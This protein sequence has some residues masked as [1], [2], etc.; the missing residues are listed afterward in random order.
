MYQCGKLNWFHFS[1]L[2]AMWHRSCRNALN[3]MKLALFLL[4]P[5]SPFSWSIVEQ[6]YLVLKEFGCPMGQKS[7]ASYPPTIYVEK[8]IEKIDYIQIKLLQVG[9]NVIA[10][11][12]ECHLKWF[13][14][15][16][17]D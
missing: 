6:A 7:T 5:F 12:L 14:Q 15:H 16:S 2:F 13:N 9:H 17:I 8:S 11:K 4:V 3:R 10:V 1:K